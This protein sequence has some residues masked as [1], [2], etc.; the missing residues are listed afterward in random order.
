MSGSYTIDLER[1]MVFMSHLGIVTEPEEVE[2]LNS[3]LSDPTYRKGMDFYCDLTRAEANWSL[4]EI[5]HFQR[6]VSKLVHLTG[7]CRWAV[8]F[9]PDA[10]LRT[11]EK[12]V[13]IH[14]GFR[15]IIEVKIFT[16]RDEGM[17]WL[18]SEELATATVP[19]EINGT[20]ESGKY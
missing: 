13:E 18:Q 15:E 5:E 12:F 19:I 1:G 20:K 3:I 17:A 14:S 10:N 9:S 6:F 7:R 4:E 8:I 16:N 2:L 11:A